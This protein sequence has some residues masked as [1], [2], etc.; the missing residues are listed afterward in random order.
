[1]KKIF[2]F[3]AVA[4]VAIGGAANGALYPMGYSTVLPCDYPAS[5]TCEIMTGFPP[6]TPV[7]SLPVSSGHQTNDHGTLDELCYTGI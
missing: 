6:S 5:P 1:M 3:A 4:W 2:F 7:S